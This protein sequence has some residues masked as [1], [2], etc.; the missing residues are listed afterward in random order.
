MLDIII[1]SDNMTTVQKS[2]KAIYM[3]LVNYEIE[4]NTHIFNSYED[5]ELDNIINNKNRKIYVLDIDSDNICNVVD[6]IREKDFTSIIILVNVKN[7]NYD[8][9]INKRLMAL[10]FIIDNDKYIIRL[11]DDINL[12]LKIIY[13]EDTLVFKYNHIIY[14]IPFGDI[15]YIEKE[16]TVK[17]C[18]IHT[19]DKNYY[20]VSS[21]EKIM[22]EF[23]DNFL[24]T[25]Q[26]CIININNVNRFDFSNNIIMFK[27][28]DYTLL[29][30]NKIKKTLRESVNI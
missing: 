15:N 11:K 9:L 6:L 13:G 3:A 1:F 7:N 12:S 20:I 22:N 26:S 2:N 18:I 29:L 24:R 8:L 17:R 19:I 21:I 16:P 10:D 14:R 5:K 27:N 28:G 25:H 23:N 30:T 4:Y